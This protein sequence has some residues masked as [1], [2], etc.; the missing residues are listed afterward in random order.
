MW[1]QTQYCTGANYC[2]FVVYTKESILIEQIKP[3]N[4]FWEENV[5]KA[6]NLG[7]CLEGAFPTLQNKLCHHY[8]LIYCI[9]TLS[10]GLLSK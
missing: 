6:K 4:S 10:P 2:D 3:D 5:R 9:A 1:V 8:L 7:S